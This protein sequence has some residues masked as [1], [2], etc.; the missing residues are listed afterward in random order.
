MGAC[1]GADLSKHVARCMLGGGGL[2]GVGLGA[3]SGVATT[4]QSSPQSC[5]AFASQASGRSVDLRVLQAGQQGR[6]LKAA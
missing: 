1:V 5:L 3:Y 2:L 6:M 4:R